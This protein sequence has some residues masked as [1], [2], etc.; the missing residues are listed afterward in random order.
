VILA[1]VA[2]VEDRLVL[3]VARFDAA[4]RLDPSFGDG[5]VATHD[6]IGTGD[7]RGAVEAAD[8][9]I[10]VVGTFGDETGH[11]FGSYAAA[12][13]L[14]PDGSL[15]RTFGDGGVVVAEVGRSVFRSVVAMPNGDVVAAG[16]AVSDSSPDVPLLAW[17]PAR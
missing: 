10:V 8:G 1:G 13:R 7:V 4:G 6:V 9:K 15:D 3:L 2:N 12:A 14:A 11:H 16:G 5:G 17:F